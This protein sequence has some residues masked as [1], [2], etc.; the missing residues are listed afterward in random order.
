MIS[1]QT[2]NGRFIRSHT[3]GGAHASPK[4]TVDNSMTKQKDINYEIIKTSAKAA[5]VK[6]NDLLALAPAND[7]FYVG[8][9]KDLEKG[10]WFAALWDRLGY[11][12]NVHLRR[13][14]Y[15]IQASGSVRLPSRVGWTDPDGSKQYTDVYINNEACWSFL[16]SSA[17][18]ARYLGLVEASAFVDRRNPDAIIYDPAPN[19]DEDG[20]IDPTPRAIIGQGWTTKSKSAPP[21]EWWQDD[22]EKFAL[23]PLPELADL[24][25]ALPRTPRLEARGYTGTPQKYLL[26]VFAEKSTMDDVLHPICNQYRVNYVRGLGEL[27]ITSVVEYLSQVAAHGRPS[28]I[29]Y[30]S[31]YDPAGIG[32]P[33]SVARKIEFYLS[34]LE[35]E[36]HDIALKQIIL[37]QEQIAHFNLPSAP[38]KS[39][40]KRKASFERDHGMATELDALESLHPGE[41]HKIVESEILQYYDASYFDAL[42]TA[43]K[44]LQHL[45]N[46]ETARVVEEHDADGKL[47][48]LANEYGEIYRGWQGIRTDFDD[49]VEQ[50]QENIEDFRIELEDVTSRANEAHEEIRED[51]RDVS[52]NAPEVP[53]AILPDEDPDDLLYDSAR[54][55]LEQLEEYKRHREGR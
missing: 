1:S 28:R 54:E 30:I 34:L 7:P 45:L 16:V 47:T 8:T 19:P 49:L 24:P 15:A 23:P 14:H 41:L 26:Y 48:E 5:G 2:K 20:Y 43:R 9:P 17:K 52:I 11:V 31:D 36:G 18:M 37:T 21:E 12:D 27:S 29:L 6:V 3:Q 4:G 32:M 46:D 40:D 22:N 38:V 13:V 25:D 55:Y 51:M 42:L 35:E 10:Q 50:F 33:I 53:E 39:S 44:G